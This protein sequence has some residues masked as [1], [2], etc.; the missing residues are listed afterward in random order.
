MKGSPLFHGL[1]PEEVD[2]A[3]SYFQRR[4]YPQGKPIF[5]QGDLGQALYLVASGKVRLFRTHLGGQERTL[6]LLGPGELFGEMS[7]L[8]EGERSASAVA[9]EDTEL[10]A[11]FR[12]DYLALIRRLPLVAQ[13]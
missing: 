11:L 2:L 9:V 7:L 13:R 1:A 4:L 8:D 10:L 3:L 6:A 12:E 5:Y